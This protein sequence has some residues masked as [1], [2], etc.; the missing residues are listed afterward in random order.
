[1]VYK[2]AASPAP[3]WLNDLKDALEALLGKCDA[4]GLGNALRSYRR[5]VFGGRYIDRVGRKHKVARWAVF[6]AVAFRRRGKDTPLTP[7]A[8][9]GQGGSGGSGGS[10][11]HGAAR[12]MEWSTT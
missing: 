12:N 2:D 10:I 5:R 3:D 4:R 7:P 11:H 6:P 1:R 9:N 8:S